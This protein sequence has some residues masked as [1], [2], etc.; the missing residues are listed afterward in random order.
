MPDEPAISRK[1]FGVL[2]YAG[3]F[4]SLMMIY[5]LSVGPVALICKNRTMPD[6]VERFYSPLAYLYRHVPAVQ[7]FY[8]WYFGFFGVKP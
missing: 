2:G 1:G 3:L 5:A 4:A 6:V 7:K 8:D